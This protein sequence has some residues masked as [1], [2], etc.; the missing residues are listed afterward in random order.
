M[1]FLPIKYL[2]APV[3]GARLRI[4]DLKVIEEK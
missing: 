1:R 2:G 4:T 3:N